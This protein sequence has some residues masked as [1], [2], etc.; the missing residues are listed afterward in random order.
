[1][2]VSLKEISYSLRLHASFTWIYYYDYLSPSNDAG[3]EMLLQS[4]FTHDS[5]ENAFCL[6]HKLF[7]LK[8][9]YYVVSSL[10]QENLV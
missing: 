6:S 2:H 8:C 7:F 3:E 10:L 4:K 5:E 1:M 9:F